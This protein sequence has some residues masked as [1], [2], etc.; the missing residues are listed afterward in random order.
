MKVI[1]QLTLVSS[2]LLLVSGAVAQSSYENGQLSK[3]ELEKYLNWHHKSFKSSEIL[4][5]G[6]NKAYDEYLN[7]KSR[8]EEVIVA[9]I[10]GGVDINHEDLKGKIWVNEDEVPGNGIDD[11][12]NGYVD[13]INGWNFLGNDE[14]ENIELEQLEITRLVEKYKDSKSELPRISN[15]EFDYEKLKEAYQQEFNKTKR[16]YSSLMQFALSYKFADSVMRANLNK[17][18]YTPEDVD[19]LETEEDTPLHFSKSFLTYVY[20]NDFDPSKLKEYG[21]HLDEKF[22]YHLNQEFAPRD[23]ILGDNPVNYDE[24]FYGNN[25]VV[26]ESSFHGTF[27]SGI[28]CAVRD[29]GIGIDGIA[30]NVKIMSIRAVPN[31]DERDKDVANAIYYAVDNGA[32]VINMSFGKQYSP[33]KKYVDKAVKYAEEHD[34]LLVHAAG[35]DAV[36]NDEIQ[37][38]PT[39]FDFEGNRIVNSWIEVGASSMH[40]DEDL[41]GSFSNYGKKS[42]DLFA[43]GVDI[44]SLEDHNTYDLSDGTSYACPMVVGVAALLRSYYPELTALE[45]KDIIMKSTYNPRRKFYK[46]GSTDKKD[47]VKLKHISKA[48]GILNAYQAVKRAE[49]KYN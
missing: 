33:G 1:N 35:N 49:R 47:R 28:I 39:A 12:D 7:N 4:G 25:D 42:V 31:G 34:V 13:D 43:P 37:H 48:G 6:T 3:K 32:K 23:S 20:S 14:G 40:R 45:V 8:N 15:R 21:E 36:N 10:D 17:E 27:V 38:Y 11:D 44:Y 26:S 46:P 22:N 29:N 2:F 9:V 30:E 18:N 24:K 41:A 16:E 19:S 5:I